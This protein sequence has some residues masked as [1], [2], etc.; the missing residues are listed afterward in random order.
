MD[1][2][3]AYA[4]ES[5]G[6]GYESVTYQLAMDQS[7]IKCLSIAKAQSTSLENEDITEKLQKHKHF[8]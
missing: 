4:Y 5:I 7:L 1:E 2:I 8:L 3:I 6:D